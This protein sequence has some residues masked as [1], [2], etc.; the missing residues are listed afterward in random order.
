VLK[1]HLASPDLQ[2]K[3]FV[4]FFSHPRLF[5]VFTSGCVVRID[6]IELEITTLE[7]ELS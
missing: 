7:R 3:S 2:V 6:G 4:Q 1:F 5:L